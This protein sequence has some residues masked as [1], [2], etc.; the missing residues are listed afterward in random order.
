MYSHIWVTL[1]AGRNILWGSPAP[2]VLV[3]DLLWG[4]IYFCYLSHKHVD[5]GNVPKRVALCLVMLAV[6]PGSARP[7]RFLEVKARAREAEEARKRR[8]EQESPQPL[9]DPVYFRASPATKFPHQINGLPREMDVRWSS[10]HQEQAHQVDGCP[11]FPAQAVPGSTPNQC[12]V[13]EEMAPATPEEE[14][15]PLSP[16]PFDKTGP[17]DPGSDMR[18]QLMWLSFGTTPETKLGEEFGAPP[19]SKGLFNEGKGSPVVCNARQRRRK[20]TGG[21]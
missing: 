9:P 21:E 4:A 14:L 16:S 13:R 5:L 2:A 3:A 20:D 11:G 15:E 7:H 19:A 6:L 18:T 1:L 10:A 8:R 17:E 12:N